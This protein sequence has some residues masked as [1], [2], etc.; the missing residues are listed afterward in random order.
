MDSPTSSSSIDNYYYKEFLADGGESTDEE[1]EQEV[2]TNACQLTTRYIKHVSWPPPQIFPREYTE[3]DQLS[4]NA[5]LMKEYF[6]IAPTYPNPNVFRRCF[7]MSKRLFLRTAGDL[8]NKF[9]YFK[10]KPDARGMLGFTAIQKCTSA[11]RVLAYINTT[12]VNNEYLKIA[13][14]TTR[15]TLEG[16]HSLSIGLFDL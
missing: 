10:Q 2:I 12:D 3:R 6:D 13:E 11:L 8:E 4:A 1:V 9:D 14:K 15:D 7:W 5:G 16:R